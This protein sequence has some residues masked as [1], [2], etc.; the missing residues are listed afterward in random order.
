MAPGGDQ[1]V[2]AEGDGRAEDG[3]DIVRVGD[4]VEVDNIR[5]LITSIGIRVSTIYTSQ[6][7]AM[8]IPNSTL[9]EQRLFNWT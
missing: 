8:H 2:G 5:G 6:G 1:R 9:V 3:A 7:M 4:L